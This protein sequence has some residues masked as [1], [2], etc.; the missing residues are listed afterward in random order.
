[1]L[2]IEAFYLSFKAHL[3]EL[4]M[5][6]WRNIGAIILTVLNFAISACAISAGVLQYNNECDYS[7]A[8]FSLS[9]WLILY[10]SVNIGSSIFIG[11]FWHCTRVIQLATIENQ[12]RLYAPLVVLLTVRAAWDIVWI[13]FGSIVMAV[14]A[15]CI[16]NLIFSWIVALVVLILIPITFLYTYFFVRHHVDNNG[17]SIIEPINQS[18]YV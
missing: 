6:S 7:K 3:N 9:L 8:P 12:A 16:V 2:K 11:L 15:P 10:G 13:V 18:D 5:V 17:Y 14:S 1:M 4:F